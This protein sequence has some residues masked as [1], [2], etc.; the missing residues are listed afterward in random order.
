[1][2]LLA[3]GLQLP[4][5]PVLESVHMGRR[6]A[7]TQA[8]AA[9]VA[10]ALA[11]L[12]A[13]ADVRGV[14]EN[15]PT[16]EKDCNALL[17]RLGYAPM[18]VSGG[19]SPLV[20]FIGF[21]KPANIDGFK[22]KERAFQSPLLVRF[23][24]PSG[25]LVESPSVTENGEAGNIGANNY[26]KG[27]SATFAAAPLPSGE[28]LT[29]LSKPFFQS[30]LSSQMTKDVFEDVKVKKIST[31][32]QPDGTEMLIISFGYTLLTRALADGHV[33]DDRAD[34]LVQRLDRVG[35]VRV[36]HRALRRHGKQGDAR[37]RGRV[38][39]GGAEVLD[40][41]VH[42]LGRHVQQ[43]RGVHCKQGVAVVGDQ[44]QHDG[45]LRQRAGAP[46]VEHR[47]VG[48]LQ[49]GHA[50]CKRAIIFCMPGACS[51]WMA[52]ITV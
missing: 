24:Y 37:G 33:M 39:D 19:F 48:Q 50:C 18:K 21:D 32:T 29:T 2:T 44:R 5:S 30:W 7:C 11:P 17:T 8:A 13:H 34:P 14:N 16:N 41:Y 27:D 15:R 43:I 6:G 26:I 46:H 36:E 9:L 4:T 51:V 38:Q 12:A 10:T 25:W 23:L 3:L 20:Q 52:G 35:G 42:F 49:A 45:Q 22:A 40:F 28:K 1:V 31:V 47:V